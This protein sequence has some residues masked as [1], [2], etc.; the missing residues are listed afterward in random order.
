MKKNIIAILFI[1]TSLIFSFLF[2]FFTKDILF[3]SKTNNQNRTNNVI[4][5]NEA[6][7]LEQASSTA[8]TIACVQQSSKEWNNEISKYINLLNDISNTEESQALKTSQDFWSKQ[9]K[10]DNKLIT[11]FVKNKGG[12]MYL[13][14]AESDS[15]ELKKQRAEFLKWLYEIQDIEE[16][17]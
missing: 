11:L 15:S 9:N 10:L 12:T 4:D 1:I 3:K 17:Y 7:C 8:E 5:K 2:G 16:N 13:Q 6:I 14:L